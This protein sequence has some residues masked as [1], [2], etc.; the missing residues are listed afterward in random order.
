LGLITPDVSELLDHFRIPGTRVLQF[1]F[2]GGDDN[3]HLPQN[4]T[5]NTAVYTGTHD[6]ATT[7]EWFQ[8]LPEHER[9]RVWG[10]ARRPEG[11]IRDAAR[12]LIEVAWTSPAALAITPFQDL[13][14]LGREGRMNVPGL[15]E[16]NWRWRATRHMLAPS[17]FQWLKDLTQRSDRLGSVLRDGGG[18]MRPAAG[19]R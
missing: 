11:E 18:I 6:N 9:Q 1:A 8:D 3:V 4:Y 10:L 19:V 15:A 12:V 16:G 13:L 5:T 7:R 14:N 2:D 17:N